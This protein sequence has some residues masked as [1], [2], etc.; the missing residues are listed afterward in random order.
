[1]DFSP[2]LQFP[3][4]AEAGVTAYPSDYGVLSEPCLH[5]GTE[6]FRCIFEELTFCKNT[7][8]LLIHTCEQ[9]QCPNVY[10][11]QVIAGF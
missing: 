10:G 4:L 8:N 1:M 9:R 11:F 6:I 7:I 2:E 3:L 5:C